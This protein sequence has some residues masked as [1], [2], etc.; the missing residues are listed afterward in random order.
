MTHYQYKLLE[1]GK[2]KDQYERKWS[3]KASLKELAVNAALK[4]NEIY[5]DKK[6]GKIAIW[7]G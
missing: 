5:T 7:E 2:K 6:Q 3:G 4:E 1:L